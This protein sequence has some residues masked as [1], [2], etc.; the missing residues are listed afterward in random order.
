MYF[1]EGFH[2]SIKLTDNLSSIDRDIAPVVLYK[3]VAMAIETLAE[4]DQDIEESSRLY[5]TV[6]LALQARDL[7]FTS[8]LYE[9]SNDEL[10]QF[11]Q[12]FIVRSFIADLYQEAA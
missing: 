12:S 7:F 3:Y 10:D 5:L 8:A 9:P 11:F 4:H 6:Q 2:R 1:A